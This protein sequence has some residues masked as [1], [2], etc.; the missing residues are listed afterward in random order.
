MMDIVYVNIDL[1]PIEDGAEVLFEEDLD[2]GY[3]LVVGTNGEDRIIGVEEADAIFDRM[4]DTA[5]VVRLGRSPF[6]AVINDKKIINIGGSRYFFGSVVIFKSSK[7]RK[8]ELLSD[9]DYEKAKAEFTSRLS[10]VNVNG[11]EFT[12]LEV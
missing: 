8:P 10:R 11:Q 12:A 7:D 5:L 1:D 3:L 2:D 6:M 4:S 9:D